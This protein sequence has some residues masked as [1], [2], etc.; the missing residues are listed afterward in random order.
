MRTAEILTSSFVVVGDFNPAIISPDWLE[1]NDLIG[2][3]DADVAREGSQGRPMLVSHQVAVYETGWFALQVL[4][5]QFSLTSKGAFSPATKDLAAGIFQLVPHTPVTAVGLNFLAHFKL[6]S[7]D[8]YNQV[9]DVL[10]PKKIWDTL[11]PDER[12][13]LTDLTIQVQPGIRGEPLETKSEKCISVR[14]SNK[15]KYGIFLSYNDHHDLSD[16]DKID[17]KP[18]ELVAGIID[19]EWESSWHDA[20]R[21][22]DVLLSMSLE[23]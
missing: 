19:S 6:E 17:L 9:G 4:D 11:Y 10:A 1:K 16:E 12:T 13:G 20:L 7:E 2:K 5:T 21:V 8:E 15:I 22:F 18:A 14:P 3:E 23:K